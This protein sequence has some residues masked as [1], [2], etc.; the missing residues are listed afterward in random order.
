MNTNDPSIS[1]VGEGG[2]GGRKRPLQFLDY[3]NSV[4]TKKMKSGIPRD[5]IWKIVFNM[6]H[7]VEKCLE[8][9][10]LNQKATI[11]TG[12][13]DSTN[14]FSEFDELRRLDKHFVMF[15]IFCEKT[16]SSI[17]PENYK[18]VLLFFALLSFRLFPTLLLF[19]KEIRSRT[20]QLFHQ[21]LQFDKEGFFL[22]FSSILS[23]SHGK[24]KLCIPQPTYRVL[25]QQETVVSF[26]VFPSYY[27]RDEFLQ[28][29][30]E[31]NQTQRGISTSPSTSTHSLPLFETNVTLR[32]E[33]DHAGQHGAKSL[34]L[35]N[36]ISLV[37]YLMDVQPLWR[38]CIMWVSELLDAIYALLSISDSRQVFVEDKSPKGGSVTNSSTFASTSLAVLWPLDQLYTKKCGELL[39]Q[40]KSR[41]LLHVSSSHGPQL[42][43]YIVQCIHMRIVDQ[44]TQQ[45]VEEL[46]LTN[47]WELKLLLWIS[48]ELEPICSRLRVEA[49]VLV[50]WR[51]SLIY[52]PGLLTTLVKSIMILY[53]AAVKMKTISNCFTAL[54]AV[55]AMSTVIHCLQP[56]AQ[57]VEHKEGNY[58]MK[59]SMSVALLR[60]KIMEVGLQLHFPFYL[61]E[62][63]M[64]TGLSDGRAGLICRLQRDVCVVSC[65]VLSKW[66]SFFPADWVN[67]TALKLSSSFSSIPSMLHSTSTVTSNEIRFAT[68]P[69]P[70]PVEC[71]MA[72]LSS[73]LCRQAVGERIFAS[74]MEKVLHSFESA[75]NAVV[76]SCESLFPT[77]LF[78]R[79]FITF[80]ALLQMDWRYYVEENL[81][82]FE[83]LLRTLRSCI[84]YLR[85]GV[86]RDEGIFLTNL[87]DVL[88][89]QMVQIRSLNLQQVKCSD[90]NVDALVA[91]FLT[92]L[93]EVLHCPLSKD[94]VEVKGM[95][96]TGMAFG[97]HRHSARLLS[98]TVSDSLDGTTWNKWHTLKGVSN[99]SCVRLFLS[100]LGGYL[101]LVFPYRQLCE[102]VTRELRLSSS[103]SFSSQTKLRDGA[104]DDMRAPHKLWLLTLLEPLFSIVS[105]VQMHLQFFISGLSQLSYQEL[106][107]RCQLENWI[108]A[109]KTG[110]LDSLSPS[111]FGSTV[112]I[113][114]KDDE[115]D[116]EQTNSAAVDNVTR[117]ERSEE[118]EV[119][120]PASSDTVIEPHEY[121]NRIRTILR[122]KHRGLVKTLCEVL[123]WLTLVNTLAECRDHSG[124]PSPSLLVDSTTTRS[125]LCRAASAAFCFEFIPSSFVP[126]KPYSISSSF[127]DG[128]TITVE[129]LFL[130]HVLQDSSYV[131]RY[132]FGGFALSLL[133]QYF[134]SFSFLQMARMKWGEGWPFY[135]TSL[136]AQKAEEP[137]TAKIDPLQ[138]N[139]ES[140]RK[141]LI[142]IPSVSSW[143]TVLRDLFVMRVAYSS[144]WR[145]IVFSSAGIPSH[146]ILDT[147]PTSITIYHKDIE[148]LLGL[149][150]RVISGNFFRFSYEKKKSGAAFRSFCPPLLL[151]F[152]FQEGLQHVANDAVLDFLRTLRWSD[153]NVLRG[154]PFLI[155]DV[156]SY[157]HGLQRR[158]GRLNDLTRRGVV[159]ELLTYTLDKVVGTPHQNEFL[160]PLRLLLS[161]EDEKSVQMDVFGPLMCGAV[162]A[163]LLWNQREEKEESALSSAREEEELLSVLAAS[164]AMLEGDPLQRVLRRAFFFL[165]SLQGDYLLE[166]ENTVGEEACFE[167]VKSPSTV[168]WYALLLRLV[169]LKN[170]PVFTPEHFRVGAPEIGDAPS[171]LSSDLFFI[172]NM[173]HKCTNIEAVAF[174]ILSKSCSGYS[175]A[176]R[177]WLL[178]LRSLIPFLG[179]KVSLIMSY[180]YSLLNSFS[181]DPDLVALVGSVWCRLL[182]HCS[183]EYLTSDLKPFMMME[184]LLLEQKCWSNRFGLMVLHNA[185]AF[186]LYDDNGEEGHQH[187]EMR[188]LFNA[189]ET[190]HHFALQRQSDLCFGA[191]YLHL[192]ENSSRMLYFYGLREKEKIPMKSASF[193]DVIDSFLFLFQK[194]SS[195]EGKHF[196]LHTLYHYLHELSVDQRLR[197]AAE[198]SAKVL[199]LVLFKAS[200]EFSDDV[201]EILLRTIGLIGA[202]SFCSLSTNNS[203][204]LATP[205]SNASSECHPVL[206]S[207]NQKGDAKGRRSEKKEVANEDGGAVGRNV[208]SSSFTVEKEEFTFSYFMSWKKMMLVLLN[209]YVPQALSGTDMLVHLYAAFASQELIRMGIERENNGVLIQ[210][211]IHHNKLHKF[212]WWRDLS[213]GSR[214]LLEVFTATDYRQR[215]RSKSFLSDDTHSAWRFHFY[216]T[217]SDSCSSVRIKKMIVPLRRLVKR[218]PPLMTWLLPYVVL[219][220]LLHPDA[221]AIIIQ[222]FVQLYEVRSDVRFHD[223]LQTLLVLFEQL[224]HARWHFDV[225]TL[226]KQMLMDLTPE[227]CG[228]LSK[229]IFSLLHQQQWSASKPT[230]K[231][232]VEVQ[233][234]TKEDGSNSL[235]PSPNFQPLPSWVQRTLTAFAIGNAIMSLR[236]MEAQLSMPSMNDAKRFL[237]EDFVRGLFRALGDHDTLQSLSQGI[238]VI[239]PAEAAFIAEAKG[240]WST[241]IQNCELVLQKN[242]HSEPHQ[243]LLLR[244]LRHLG[245]LQLASQYA[246]NLRVRHRKMQMSKTAR[247]RLEQDSCEAA[248][249]LGKWDDVWNIEPDSLSS[250]SSLAFPLSQW[251]KFLRGYSSISSV[252]SS[253]VHQRQKLIPM[254]RAASLTDEEQLYRYISILH[255]L[256]DLEYTATQLQDFFHHQQHSP[257]EYEV[258]MDSI[259][260]TL[261]QRLSSTV[262]DIL[263][264]KEPLLS[265]HR[266]MVEEMPVRTEATVT[267]LAS[268]M[269]S[270]V[271][272]LRH[273]GYPDGALAVA[274]QSYNHGMKVPTSLCVSLAELMYETGSKVQAS[275][276]VQHSVDQ[277]YAVNDANSSKRHL[278]RSAQVTSQL[279]VLLTD[280]KMEAS[281]QTQEEIIRGYERA[282]SMNP[283]EVAHHKLALFYEKI[284]L[285]APAPQKVQGSDASGARSQQN[286]Q[287]YTAALKA[288]EHFGQALAIGCE[289]LLVSLPRMLTLWLDTVYELTKREELQ[290]Q[291]MPKKAVA[292]LSE[293]GKDIQQHQ[294]TSLSDTSSFL[295][296][297]RMNDQ[298]AYLVNGKSSTNSSLIPLSYLLTALPQLLSRLGHPNARVVDIISE[299][300][301]QLLRHFPQPCLWQV[302]P[303]AFGRPDA[304]ARIVKERILDRFS[305]NSFA[306]ECRR[307]GEKIFES[308]IALCNA[309]PG[310]FKSG[311]KLSEMPF[312]KD[313]SSLVQTYDFIL[314]TL[315]NLTPNVS[316][317]GKGSDDV[318]PCKKTFRGFDD[319]VIL[320]KSK[321][322]PKRIQ[323]RSNVGTLIPFLCKADDE[324][325]KDMRMM[326]LAALMNKFFLQNSDARRRGLSLHRYSVA[327]L[328][329]SC[330]IIEWVKDLAPFYPL[331]I[332]CY[333][334]CRLG[335]DERKI[336]ALFDEAKKKK[337]PKM[338]VLKN[339]ILPFFPP[340]FHCW[341]DKQFQTNDQWYQARCLYTNSAALW[342][343]AGHV[344]GLGDRH[345]EN[346]LLNQRTGEAMHV[347][348]A[349]MFDSAEN[350]PVPEVVRFR[351]TPNVIDGFGIAG[352]SGSF[353]SICRLALQCQM[354]NLNALMSIAE[355]HLYEPSN[356]CSNFSIQRISRRLT[357]YLDFYNPQTSSVFPLSNVSLNVEG[358]VER[359]I[360]HSS[361]LENLSEMYTWWRPWI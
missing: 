202:I 268:I 288:V 360:S 188:S 289:T 83:T 293:K 261:Q 52:T 166:K 152:S 318:Y 86:Y 57:L 110:T 244:S 305:Q 229:A 253:C 54:R 332:G 247:R 3:F 319:T 119:V 262:E 178:A 208:L 228:N 95:L 271:H 45:D 127:P 26:S 333:Q 313:V 56:C 286:Q 199:L 336:N 18:G 81:S 217:L 8:I 118:N 155:T 352:T 335:L 25:P 1:T 97:L 31:R 129:Q 197:L 59:D 145:E 350:L 88:T 309:A 131:T 250:V 46:D 103:G 9:I 347:D 180:L 316:G 29:L 321:Q 297:E 5:D 169:S 242:E 41:Q 235:F 22:F 272:L 304:T 17:P 2:R 156:L 295:P 171:Q 76:N 209:R 325:R 96:L 187:E 186:L 90:P 279:Q 298:I 112:V 359:L 276:F 185:M 265:L 230:E 266:R 315:H 210:G 27:Y 220:A 310:N 89:Q 184:L 290:L 215:E 53:K 200:H 241:A 77:M 68:D 216:C 115:S 227:A 20:F 308:L 128:F 75:W 66:L 212:A 246:E 307:N 74:E 87:I 353:Q 37:E 245:Q 91:L 60:Q 101:A 125:I 275:T 38:P 49:P 269:E 192:F 264:V 142:S 33:G 238:A 182:Q 69:P 338:D 277:Y 329:S 274:K 361:S 140:K 317:K 357:G 10:E 267:I 157:L 116:V 233:N 213:P 291:E 39:L 136:S 71:M 211:I 133:T 193:A 153:A 254:V 292:T 51:K 113:D 218:F 330:A 314:P 231:S 150:L 219:D 6:R 72:L 55:Y 13:I 322:Q 251:V 148:E 190:S 206:S 34:F 341:F 326:D 337:V 183:K 339:Q 349:E 108:A 123:H 121:G 340:I 324:P 303:L 172:V 195:L 205:S 62:L 151:R 139:E 176:R 232:V 270:H 300:V 35:Y 61:Q 24:L 299:I 104:Q 36:V 70:L 107:I 222:Y 201:V 93:R 105:Q 30:T 204:F 174:P 252:Y 191:S 196:L 175:Q 42:F 167:E 12:T 226:Q 16:H 258:C 177:K 141:K 306:S 40:M 257:A 84:S 302:L 7:E 111:S 284:F 21:L 79:S 23:E 273:C 160:I 281:D 32:D 149:S 114:V 280:W 283:S 146:P 120:L 85:I 19:R 47:S 343:M 249:R 282:I 203:R 126:L 137:E 161:H 58:S 173:I 354:K 344:V 320:M 312:M 98:Y 256:C 285:S 50:L 158:R 356:R 109:A 164:K 194:G 135:R 14:P 207:E 122:D 130:N 214:Q 342:S 328:S 28:T 346:L 67:E 237:G 179:D 189:S 102:A 263:D 73:L 170:V 15:H 223:R 181:Q 296:I 345:G 159:Q 287:R 239:D 301:V 106:P 154:D 234:E 44:S 43:Y 165:L 99:D 355:T 168:A 48:E 248:W 224:Q 163:K 327:A 124:T 144:E 4:P 221:P 147:P 64:E 198:P 65:K 260:S 162:V 117:N 11:A 92:C 236:F 78:V 358:Q 80:C 138:E 323:V 240:E 243:V 255:G 331:V 132:G 100:V 143:S 134:P 259:L 278:D 351:L 63:L 311:A 294:T 225:F 334:C 348:F 94:K 82:L